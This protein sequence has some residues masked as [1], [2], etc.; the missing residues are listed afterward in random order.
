MKS[1]SRDK[2][3]NPE[4]WDL[5]TPLYLNLN[6]PSPI[7][8]PSVLSIVW[9]DCLKVPSRNLDPSH[10][11]MLN[12]TYQW[13]SEPSVLC[14]PDAQRIIISDL[15]GH[16]LENIFPRDAFFFLSSLFFEDFEYWIRFSSIQ[17]RIAEKFIISHVTDLMCLKGITFTTQY[18]VAH[19]W[20]FL[21]STLYMNITIL[22]KIKGWKTVC[23]LISS[24]KNT[25]TAVHSK[26][27]P[28]EE[29]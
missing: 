7:I 27:E 1:N 12:N 17:L 22:V 14:M 13:S 18:Y 21:W 8:P 20:W 5:Y 19:Y 9:V 25:V 29:L 4:F 11:E 23:C 10:Q 26:L 24:S 16:K 28:T 6:S 15:L 2:Q 3:S